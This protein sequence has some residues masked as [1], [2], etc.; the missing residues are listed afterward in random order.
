MQGSDTGVGEN[1]SSSSAPSSP[2]QTPIE[3]T[4]LRFTRAVAPD[5][6]SVRTVVME[7]A[8]SASDSIP[9]RWPSASNQI[10][11][12]LGSAYEAASNRSGWFENADDE[13]IGVFLR[14]MHRPAGAIVA[15]I[16]NERKL[17]EGRMTC[18]LE[19]MVPYG[20][21]DEHRITALMTFARLCDF[22]LHWA[23]AFC[24][25]HSRTAR[26]LLPDVWFDWLDA[27]RQEAALG[28][29]LGLEEGTPLW[30]AYVSKVSG[31][32]LG[33]GEHELLLKVP[34]EIGAR[35]AD[36]RLTLSAWPELIIPQVEW[37]M[38]RRDDIVEYDETLRVEKWRNP[39][40]EDYVY[41]A[42]EAP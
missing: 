29:I 23:A 5:P 15:N 22:K 28:Q 8:T 38:L 1:A 35:I 13:E 41:P 7:H 25:S 6:V 32:D 24:L 14:T 16:Q 21:S 36:G 10:L 17:A 11:E 9:L 34:I 39:E 19:G 27:S 37:R 30:T 20:W 4:A 40:G 3:Q 42:V 12:N 2:A 31:Y 26:D 18:L 33:S